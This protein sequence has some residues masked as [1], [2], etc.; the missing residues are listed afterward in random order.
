[1]NS[2][3]SDV[4]RVIKRPRNIGI[5]LS[6]II[7]SVLCIYFF[8]YMQWR[9]LVIPIEICITGYIGV[10]IAAQIHQAIF[11]KVMRTASQGVIQFGIII[12]LAA[13]LDNIFFAEKGYL[14]FPVIATLWLW[15]PFQLARLLW[16][17]SE[18]PASQKKIV[19]DSTDVLYA[20]IAHLRQGMEHALDYYTHIKQKYKL[21]Q[22]YV[23]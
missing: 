2:T 20:Q 23:H 18:M 19:T 8:S 3:I 12:F 11:A 22:P 10:R 21:T 5:I 7:L 17:L 1:M 9:R 13:V 14:T 4:K 16:R 15:I 6:L